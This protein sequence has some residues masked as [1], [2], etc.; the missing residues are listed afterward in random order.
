[1]KKTAILFAL[2]AVVSLSA[3]A[4][5]KN[6]SSSEPPLTSSNIEITFPDGSALDEDYEYDP[7]EHAIPAPADAAMYRGE[8]QEITAAGNDLHVYLK[9]VEGT[10]FGRP[11][12]LVR[13]LDD[14][15]KRSFE[16]LDIKPG[17]YLE[18]YYGVTLGSDEMP[19]EV[20]AI[21]VNRLPDAKHSIVNATLKE[22]TPSG[23]GG[24]LWV[25]RLEN[26]EE[27]VFSCG[28][29]T[30]FYLNKETLKPGDKLNIFFSGTVRESYPL[31]ADALEVR[32]F[33][34]NAEDIKET[35]AVN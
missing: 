26:D 31:Q 24:S 3:C 5:Q 35:P 23:S 22:F 14:S 20:D 7:G 6:E 9:Q 11:E 19:D 2:L 30:Q 12:L 10:D 29:E 27:I 18:V 25:A 32:H 15:T 28:D 17:E 16:L 33:A 21:V 13:L 34:E 4:S 1:M 8:V